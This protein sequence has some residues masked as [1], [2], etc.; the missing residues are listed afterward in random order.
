MARELWLLRHGEAEPGGPAVRDADRRLTPRGED[1]ARAAGRMLA[2]LG[3]AFDLVAT[4]PKARALQTAQLV[5]EPLGA[6]VTVHDPLADGFDLDAALDLGAMAGDDG[7]VLAIG[8]NPDFAQIVH[9]LTGARARL[10][11]GAI[12][13]IRLRAVIGELRLLVRPADLGI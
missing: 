6:D 9:D 10:G 4:S 3:V 1:Q 8:H 11:T 12:A 13:A 2:H 7:W 5:A